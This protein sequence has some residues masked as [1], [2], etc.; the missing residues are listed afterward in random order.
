MV[1]SVTALL[2]SLLTLWDLYTSVKAAKSSEVTEIQF[3]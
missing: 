3:E 1:V 2:Y